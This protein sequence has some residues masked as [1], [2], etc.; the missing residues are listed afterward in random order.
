MIN[1]VILYFIDTQAKKAGQNFIG[2]F[3]KLKNPSH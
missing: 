1:I 2:L 3:A